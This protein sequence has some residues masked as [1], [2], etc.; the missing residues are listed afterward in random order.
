M[1]HPALDELNKIMKIKD[2]TDFCPEKDRQA[3]LDSWLEKWLIEVE[4]SQLVVNSKL[5]NSEDTDFVKY[6]MGQV[7]GE[8]LTEECVTFKTTAQRI[9]G[10][11]IGL[12]RGK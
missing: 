7:L 10:H 9:S 1:K 8:S 5:L 4:Q 11:L 2:W 3:A 6:R 12:R